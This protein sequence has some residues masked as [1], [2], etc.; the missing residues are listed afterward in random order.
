MCIPL[1]GAEL[2][3]EV[4]VRGRVGVELVLPAG[5]AV[6]PAPP[7]AHRALP[8]EATCAA[9]CTLPDLLLSLCVLDVAA[10]YDPPLH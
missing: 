4:H 2:G 7:R 10:V 6:W 9:C 3:V 1:Q 5:A 8:G